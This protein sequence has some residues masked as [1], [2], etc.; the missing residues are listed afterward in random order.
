VIPDF[1]ITIEDGTVLLEMNEPT[2]YVTAQLPVTA[3][4]VCQIPPP[5]ADP[6][7]T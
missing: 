3:P 1:E 4:S 2:E 7:K 5:N 6:L